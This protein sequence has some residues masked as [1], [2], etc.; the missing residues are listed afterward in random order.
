MEFFQN[1]F[2][3]GDSRQTFLPFLPSS[4]RSTLKTASKK[5]IIEKRT[6]SIDAELDL[7][8]DNLGAN[9][10]I[11]LSD[12][13]D[14]NISRESLTIQQEDLR[15]IKL[16]EL[17]AN[18]APNTL[19][20]ALRSTTKESINPG[21][22]TFKVVN[23]LQEESEE[24]IQESLNIINKNKLTVS[25]KQLFS[26]SYDKG[27][28]AKK[29]VL[30]P[31]RKLSLMNIHKLYSD[32]ISSENLLERSK[33]DEGNPVMHMKNRTSNNFMFGM[34]SEQSM[35][36]FGRKLG[37]LKWNQTVNGL[38]QGDP[39]KFKK[40][41][42]EYAHYLD[43]LSQVKEIRDNLDND[44]QLRPQGAYDKKYFDNIYAR[45]DYYHNL[46]INLHPEAKQNILQ[47][48]NYR[49]GE[50][51][52]AGQLQFWGKTK[53]GRRLMDMVSDEASQKD[54]SFAEMIFSPGDFGQNH[55]T[56]AAVRRQ[57]ETA[58]QRMHSNLKK[59]TDE[60][61]DAYNALY[62]EKYGLLRYGT[63][64]VSNLPLFRFLYSK[65]KISQELFGKLQI[66]KSK[67][68][69]VYNNKTKK[70]ENKY[71]NITELNSKYFD[72]NGILKKNVGSLPEAE[73][74]SKAELN[75]ANLVSRYTTFY[76][77]LLETKGLFSDKGGRKRYVPLLRASRYE[78]LRRRGLYGLYWLKHSNKDAMFNNM[79]VTAYNPM[80]GKTET[81]PY[82]EFKA[83]Y[84]TSKNEILQYKK[85]YAG[86]LPNL[87]LIDI[88]AFDTLTRTKN[89]NKLV[90]NAK[91]LYTTGKDALGNP[92]TAVEGATDVIDA[93]NT[94][95]FNRYLSTRSSK[96][97]YTATFNMHQA[98]YNYLKTMVFQYG[99]EYLGNDG[100]FKSLQFKN[101]PQGKESI[102]LSSLTSKPQNFNG[103]ENYKCMIDGAMQFLRGAGDNNQN[104]NSVKYLK[105][106]VLDR[107]IMGK[108][109]K[110]ITGSELERKAVEKLTRWTM[111]IGLGINF[112]AAGFNIAIGKYNAWRSLGT[113]K[114][115]KS[116]MRVFGIGQNGLWDR[117]M[118]QKAQLILEEYGILT[119][120]PE[121]Q[122]EDASHGTLIDKILFFPMTTAEKWIQRAQ[123]VGEMTDEQWNSYDIDENGK[124][125]ITD[126][127]NALNPD[128][129]AR[130][131][132]AVQNVQ[133]R[134]YSDADQRLLQVYA[135]G[136]MVMQFK[137]WFPTYLV[138]RLGKAGY[139][140]YIDDFGKTYSGSVSTFAKHSMESMGNP[141]SYIKNYKTLS[142]AEKQALDRFH[143][144]QLGIVVM[145]L[146]YLM[147]G[148]PEG[149]TSDE[150]EAF[151]SALEQFLGDMLLGLNLPKLGY[152][153][154]VPAISTANNLAY[155][156]IQG[157]SGA[158][159][160]RDSKYGYRGEKK[161]RRY[162]AALLP[163]PLRA[164]LERKP[165]TSERLRK[166]RRER[167]RRLEK[168]RGN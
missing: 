19:K 25:D 128:Q 83:I 9:K 97:S 132:R 85:E 64:V 28:G 27:Q 96:S 74:L 59:V 131:V 139:R 58:N 13:I 52:T 51:I 163:G 89:L 38:E 125:I 79:M 60:L 143:R 63:K 66:Q 67:L 160:T 6:K 101:T 106:V 142:K 23:L 55:P 43:S 102:I 141:I 109:K 56:L 24:S 93:E 123:F 159:Y 7:L 87:D 18:F 30:E 33:D 71:I 37:F 155:V 31:S 61:N 145:G 4:V 10:D 68:I 80:T 112:T 48:L 44:N 152:M 149:G 116:H 47:E 65:E 100:R 119:Y 81:K 107:F 121:D 104:A 2:G 35:D 42:Q 1:T 46:T 49:F 82:S 8:N 75:Y 50:A 122:L 140:E 16:V 84:N 126:Q 157:L 135:M 77:K 17:M 147:S 118:A 53:D 137:R 164:G 76:K 15:A 138:D 21:V 22:S 151:N 162:L 120:R 45:L 62:K 92:I 144:G 146:L 117:R 158:E 150:E 98:M 5:M 168:R 133:G 95:T 129:V 86:R 108:P 57:I 111:M 114:F 69:A 91:Q 156:L 32:I 70:L 72:D 36:A 148:G 105:D 134:G 154:T 167:R 88:D 29:F 20:K 110:L 26:I 54:I 3:L 113:Q 161:A 41:S 166:A 73:R 78:I 94:K 40:L 39:A 12:L 14:A 130:K 103:F 11:L 153:A 34:E 124:L 136:S 165:K 90:K 115:L 127:V 99:T